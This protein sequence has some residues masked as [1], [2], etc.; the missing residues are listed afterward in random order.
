MSKSKAS[1]Y[2]FV[3]LLKIIKFREPRGLFDKVYNISS[4]NHSSHIILKP[5]IT[6]N[7][8]MTN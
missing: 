2:T 8:V 5:N 3:E 1:Y 4:N 7:N 6:Q